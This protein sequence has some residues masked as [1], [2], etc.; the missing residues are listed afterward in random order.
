MREKRAMEKFLCRS[1]EER[2]F[3]FVIGECLGNWLFYFRVEKFAIDDLYSFCLVFV[4][5]FF[6]NFAL[7]FGF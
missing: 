4:G 2:K 1:E 5:F 7:I 6:S 3:Q